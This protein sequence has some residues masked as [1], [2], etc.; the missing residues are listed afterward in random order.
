MTTCS[1]LDHTT[2]L[3]SDALMSH[4]VFFEKLK[5][6]GGEHLPR[7]APRD[8]P[9]YGS[10]KPGREVVVT[11]APLSIRCVMLTRALPVN[12][13]YSTPIYIIEQDSMIPGRAV[14]QMGAFVDHSLAT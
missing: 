14:R 9:L 2:S 11:D 10:R 12:T 5:W 13:R 7:P 8:A 1:H 4:S 3:K 6:Q